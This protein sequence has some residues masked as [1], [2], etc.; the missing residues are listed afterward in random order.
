MLDEGHRVYL[1]DIFKIWV[2][3]PSKDQYIPL[4]KQDHNRFIQVLR[5]ELEVFTPLAIITWGVKAR[6]MVRNLNLGVRH[7]AFPHPSGSAN[8]EWR[9]LIGKSPTRENK[10][11]F[12]RLKVSGYLASIDL[13]R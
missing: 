3:Q 8:G 5:A 12:W 9:K 7:L 10:I 13:V 1:T 4:S 2:S 6:D 11:E